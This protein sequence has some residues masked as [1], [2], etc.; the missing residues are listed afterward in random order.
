MYEELSL[1]CMTTLFISMSAAFIIVACIAMF[2]FDR[3]EKNYLDK[4][5]NIALRVTVI[6]ALLS[7]LSLFLAVCEWV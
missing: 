4:R 1:D 5:A 7:V 6:S 2:V 3:S